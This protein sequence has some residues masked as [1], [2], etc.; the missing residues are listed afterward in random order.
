MIFST[1]LSY[2]SDSPL[3]LNYSALKRRLTG[4]KLSRTVTFSFN[5]NYQYENILIRKQSILIVFT[6][7]LQKG[8]IIKN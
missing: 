1:S 6:E 2:V 8:N 3:P 4:N 7:Q 5:C